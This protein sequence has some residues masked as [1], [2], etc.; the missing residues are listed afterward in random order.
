MDFL[1]SEAV[2]FALTN[3][4]SI[5]SKATKKITH[6]PF[7]LFPTAFPRIHYQNSLEIQPLLNQL[8][9]KLSL[10]NEFIASAMERCFKI[11]KYYPYFIID[12]LIEVD[13][14]QKNLYKIHCEVLKSKKSKNRISLLICRSDYMLHYV[15]DTTTLL[16]QVEFNTISCGLVSLAPIVTR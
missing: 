8:F 11:N 4:L 10:D 1:V 3:G 6:A 9:Y 16:Q 2:D 14:F 13:D 12:S 7:S 15:N 5:K